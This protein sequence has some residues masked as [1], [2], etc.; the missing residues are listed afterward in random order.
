MSQEL[1]GLSKEQE[2]EE[3]RKQDGLPDFFLKGATG[4]CMDYLFVLLALP[5]SASQMEYIYHRL[6]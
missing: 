6:A 3:V 1:K 4:L 2:A 5:C